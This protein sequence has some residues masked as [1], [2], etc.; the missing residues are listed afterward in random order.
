MSTNL[1]LFC[2]VF[3]T[4]VSHVG[5]QSSVSLEFLVDFWGPVRP[6]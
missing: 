6:C 5:I 3:V 1:T 4:T 2:V